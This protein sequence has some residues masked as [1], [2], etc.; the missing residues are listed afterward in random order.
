[1]FHKFNVINVENT[2]NFR[3]KEYSQHLLPIRKFFKQ[4]TFQ[5]NLIIF[6]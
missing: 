5:I 6:S 1:M 4:K 2:N 3:D